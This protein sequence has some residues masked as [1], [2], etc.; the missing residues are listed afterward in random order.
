MEPHRGRSVLETGG[1]ARRELLYLGFEGRRRVEST[2]DQKK[3]ISHYWFIV[4]VCNRSYSNEAVFESLR[5]LNCC[6]IILCSS[7]PC[8]ISVNLLSHT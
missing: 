1:W 2:S 3:L 4:Y 6:E 8:R 7:S 5:P